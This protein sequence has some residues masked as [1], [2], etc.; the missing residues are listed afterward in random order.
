MAESISL[1]ILSVLFPLGM[2]L[3]ARRYWFVIPRRGLALALICLVAAAF[4]RF[5]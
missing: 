1:N 2:Y 3:T 4:L 5:I